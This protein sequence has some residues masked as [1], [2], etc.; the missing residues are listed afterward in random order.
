MDLAADPE[1]AAEAHDERTP[2]S[3]IDMRTPGVVN[4]RA[5]MGSAVRMS[6]IIIWSGTEALEQR[7]LNVQLDDVDLEGVGRDV[8][9]EGAEVVND[10]LH[11]HRALGDARRRNGERRNRRQ[12]GGLEFMGLEAVSPGELLFGNG[13]ATGGEREAVNI[14]HLILRRKIDDALAGANE[15]LRGLPHGAQAEHGAPS[16]P[17]TRRHGRD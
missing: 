5:V 1:E 11:L 10:A 4:A 9:A 8:F 6:A 16:Q 2:A 3:G 12:A 17:P 15:I 7:F 13:I 14:R